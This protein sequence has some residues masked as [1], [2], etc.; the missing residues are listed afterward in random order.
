MELT[1]EK[2]QEMEEEGKSAALLKIMYERDL[3]VRDLL[4]WLLKAQ[5]FDVID[6]MKTE[7]IVK[8]ED[9]R[10]NTYKETAV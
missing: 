2:V 3:K 8:D 7:G 5:R 1:G 4:R 9:V 6:E 10:P